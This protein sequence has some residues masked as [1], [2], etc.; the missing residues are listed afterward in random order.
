MVRGLSEVLACIGNST[1]A[2]AAYATALAALQAAR[3]LNAVAGAS[4]P[5]R[6]MVCVCVGGGG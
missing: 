2:T 6:R 4:M 5:V 3:D 1:A